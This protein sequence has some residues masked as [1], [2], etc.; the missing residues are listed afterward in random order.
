MKTSDRKKTG[1]AETVLRHA[2]TLPAGQRGAVNP[3]LVRASTV[4]FEN[5]ASLKQASAQPFNGFYYG[6]FGTPTHAALEDALCA[7]SGA[8][9]GVFYPSGLAA[10]AGVLCSLLSAGDELLLAD[11]VYGPTRNFCIRE[12]T[13]FGISVRVFPAIAGKDIEGYIGATTRAIYCESPGSLTMEMQDLPALCAVARARDIPV[14]VDNTWATP[15][16][17]KV[18]AMGASVD[19]QAGTKYLGGHADVMLGAALCDAAVLPKIRQ[20]SQSFGYC[21]S[22]DDAWLV[23]RGLRSLDIRMR[24]HAHN[25]SVLKEWL[26]Q[27][28]EVR[29]VLDPADDTHPQHV[30]WKRDYTGGNGLFSVEID[31]L[32]DTALSALVDSLQLFGLG[33]SWGGFESLCIPFDV[34]KERDDQQWNKSSTYLRFHAGLEA[35]DDLVADLQTG[36]TA[37]RESINTQG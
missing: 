28:P 23:L 32:N 35:A 37:L 19:I 3:P 22:P 16:H 31:P 1:A 20:R 24:Q 11:C 12:L 13:R 2:G 6:R 10:T 21:V 33:Y 36:F 30:L 18:L 15:L 26:K 34:S 7:L 8:N 29:R 25:A 17:G 9:G 4:L 27:Q 14:L 5:L